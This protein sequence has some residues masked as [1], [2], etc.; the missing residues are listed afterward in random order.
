MKYIAA[1]LGLCLLLFV[2]FSNQRKKDIEDW[3]RDGLYFFW[4]P[5]LLVAVVIAEWWEKRK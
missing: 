4:G 3:V 2:I 5:F 1:Y